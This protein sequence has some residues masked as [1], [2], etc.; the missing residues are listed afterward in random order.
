MQLRCA[1]QLG[2]LAG[3]VAC[4]VVA[5]AGCN[6][7]TS[8]VALP[9]KTSP[10]HTAVTT[11][12]RGLSERQ[13]VIAAFTGYSEALRTAGNSRSPAEVRRLMDP[14]LP[15]STISNLI[16]FDQSIWAKG[17]LFYGHIARHIVAVRVDGRHAF[18]HDCD[19][20]SEAGLEDARTG[21]VVPGS[22]GIRDDN[23]ITRLN[24]VGSQWLVGIQTIEDVPCKP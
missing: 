19:N 10:T 4:A 13:Q 2:P 5:L 15:A 12:P 23:V 17:E 21:Q 18:V 3:L 9:P 20:T 6:E 7:I 14:Y 1:R 8:T 22:L 11:K 24:L 16:K